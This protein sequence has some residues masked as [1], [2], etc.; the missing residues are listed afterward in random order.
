MS[1]PIYIKSDVK[2]PILKENKPTKHKGSASP[3]EMTY[4]SS[5]IIHILHKPPKH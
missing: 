4:T 2:A 5:F 3:H 1:Q